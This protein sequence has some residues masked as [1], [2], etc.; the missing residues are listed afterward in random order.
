[1][2]NDYCREWLMI[3]WYSIMITT[4]DEWL[5]QRMINDNDYYLWW[6]IT[7]WYSTIWSID[8]YEMMKWWDVN[9]FI[10]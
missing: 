8:L 2:M 4:Y 10:F 5:L 1:M 7:E 6:M 9:I 3:Q